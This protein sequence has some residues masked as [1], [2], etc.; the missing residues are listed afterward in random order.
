MLGG[1]TFAH[2][3]RWIV[4]F[5]LREDFYHKCEGGLHRYSQIYERCASLCTQM[6]GPKDGIGAE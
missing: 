6:K 1:L 3:P 5:T 4:N 2:I